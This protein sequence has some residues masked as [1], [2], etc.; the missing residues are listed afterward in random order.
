MTVEGLTVRQKFIL[1]KLIEKGSLSLKSLSQQIDLSERTVL[2][3]TSALNEWLKQYRLR[4]TESGGELQIN[5]NAKDLTAVQALLK[6]IPPLWMLNQEQR[7]VL[8]TAQL[9]LANEPIKSAYFS[10]QFNVVEGTIVFSLDK[11]ESWLA[12]KNLNLIRKRGYGLEIQ[13]SDWQKRN[14]FVDLLYSYKSLNELLA[15]FYENQQDYPLLAFFKVT[16]GE[17]LLKLTQESLARINAQQLFPNDVRFF[18]AFIHLLLAIKR[19]VSNSP[20]TL[21][22]ALVQEV[23]ASTEFSFVQ[24]VKFILQA[25]G[26]VLPESELAYLA[27][28]LSGDNQVLEGKFGTKEL[29]I[30][31]E[32]L[33][34][35]VVYVVGKRIKLRIVYDQQLLA[36]LTQH[37]N[38][39]L[40]RLSMGLEVRNPI[41]NEI[42]QYYPK[43]YQAVNYA[44]RLVFSKFN[45]VIPES[46]VGYITMHIGA[47]I[48]RQHDVVDKK[49]SALIICPNGLSTAKIL[50][51][52]LKNNFPALKMIEI[53]SLREM[54]EKLREPFDLVF[55][56]IQ[57]ESKSADN[58]IV[59]SPFLP[60][61]EI[62]EIAK[63]VQKLSSPQNWREKLQLPDAGEH[64]GV[65]LDD[66]NTANDLLKNLQLA[67]I[68]GQNYKM[69]LD[70]IVRQIC[71]QAIC[72]LEPSTEGVLKS[73]IAKRE[74]QGNV[75]IVG[76]HIALLHVRT[77]EI[78]AP[79]IGVYRLAQFIPMKGVGFA[80][81]NVDTVFVMLARKNESNYILEQLGK[82]SVSLVENKYFAEVLRIGDLNDIRDQVVEIINQEAD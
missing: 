68:D 36:G 57:L 40:Y 22:D 46:E 49:L 7:Q 65:D 77:E 63:L 4:I 41:I 64:T 72:G 23:L 5:G 18:S 21:P 25:S 28:H 35:E 71:S 58:I 2:R 14:A 6:D 27:I 48:E 31:L 51:N 44:C 29:G 60:S 47:A 75:I 38:P 32:D 42:K 50:S 45:L 80:V 43:L 3:E 67:T 82:I 10:H 74:A 56:T 8:I 66:L 15:F 59:I 55:S 24:D 61:S 79:F 26:I 81:E 52:K 33:I 76:S 9:L 16:F 62:E 17:E 12:A 13:G 70:Q 37:I 73:L 78:N 20:I 54:N 69:T 34:K 39:A 19:T 1:H 30:D 11:I 53:C